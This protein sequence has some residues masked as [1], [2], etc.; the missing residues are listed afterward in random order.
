MK[1][2]LRKA[3]VTVL[4]AAMTMTMGACGSSS[5]TGHYRGARWCTGNR[6]G[7]RRTDGEGHGSG[8]GETE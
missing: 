3:M 2:N 8:G 4:A 1:K 6:G 7:R 5:K